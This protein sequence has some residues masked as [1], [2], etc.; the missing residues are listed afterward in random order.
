MREISGGGNRYVGTSLLPLF[1]RGCITIILHPL[2]FSVV[3]IE[4]II[5]I[6]IKQSSKN[7]YKS[8]E[9]TFFFFYGNDV[10]K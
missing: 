8:R 3:Y 5:Y 10:S 4:V 2:K 9:R 7:N 6:F 1:L